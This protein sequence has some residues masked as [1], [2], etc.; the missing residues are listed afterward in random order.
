M[1]QCIYIL[2]VYWWPCLLHGFLVVVIVT[3]SSP[4]PPL[5]LLAISTLGQCS[6]MQH[7]WPVSRVNISVSVGRCEI[8]VLFKTTSWSWSLMLKLRVGRLNLLNCFPKHV[9]DVVL[10]VFFF[11]GQYWL[12]FRYE[13]CILSIVSN[14]L[15]AKALSHSATPRRHEKLYQWSSA[16]VCCPDRKTGCLTDK[17]WLDRNKHMSVHKEINYSMLFKPGIPKKY[18]DKKTGF[19][20]P[21]S[22]LLWT[23]PTYSLHVGYTVYNSITTTL[24]TIYPLIHQERNRGS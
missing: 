15:W 21:Q 6:E 5:S 12:K 24:Q 2:Y 4:T 16:C 11:L 3:W 18:S 19:G 8:P 13:E 23:L 22:I 17:M 9:G 10:V 14:I 20:Q 1:Y 7:S